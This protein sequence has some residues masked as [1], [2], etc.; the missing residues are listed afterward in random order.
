M[1]V[2]TSL[3]IQNLAMQFFFSIHQ[4]HIRS[5]IEKTPKIQAGAE[6]PIP[7][8]MAI[9]LVVLLQIQFRLATIKKWLDFLCVKFSAQ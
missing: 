9:K 6:L 7:F 1:S 8:Q 4:Q 2:G 3:S 5:V